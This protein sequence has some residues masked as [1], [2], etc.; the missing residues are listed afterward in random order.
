MI[1]FKTVS[2]I[3]TNR[4]TWAVQNIS[5]H[6]QP[7]EVVAI[8]GA[9]GSG[10]ST[11]LKM[12]NRLIEPTSGIITIHH[13]PIKDLSPLQ[14]RRRIGYVIQ[15]HGLFPHLCVADN[16]SILLRCENY[17]KKQR[18]QRASELLAL[19]NLEPAHY[20]Q[21][22][23]SELSGGEQQRIGLAR[24]LAHNPDYLLL[25]EPFSALDILNRD[26]L[27]QKLLTLKNQLKKTIVFVTHDLREAFRLADRIAIIHAGKCEQ[28][29][30]KENLINHPATDYVAALMALAL[31]H[32]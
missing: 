32:A 22:F 29:D 4:Q 23:P 18:W 20:A 6:I 12:I 30:S 31:R 19:M 27:Q 15:H 10:K 26:L 21:R 3:F 11:I 1:E 2:K 8:V 16:I 7:Q 28:M 25:D 9:S 5:F 17:S 24:A 14:L 13:R